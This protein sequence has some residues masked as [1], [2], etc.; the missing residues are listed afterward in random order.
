M[1]ACIT[2]HV[3]NSFSGADPAKKNTDG[4]VP[5]SLI[6]S[7]V[8][9][10][11]N[12]SWDTIAELYVYI[13]MY[14]YTQVLIEQNFVYVCASV[15]MC[16]NSLHILNCINTSISFLWPSFLAFRIQFV[17]LI[18]R[19][20]NII[21]KWFSNLLSFQEKYI[22]L[23]YNFF[24]LFSAAP[25]NEQKVIKTGNRQ[26]NIPVC[27]QRSV[28]EQMKTWWLFKSYNCLKIIHSLSFV[29]SPNIPCNIF[30]IYW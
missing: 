21:L 29:L 22:F 9:L 6:A 27:N 26:E 2:T 23:P 1:Y 18:V 25:E 4:K 8:S 13:Y 15:C 19:P 17:R 3:R 30:Q 7:N 16:D 11:S 5:K 14:V 10:E 24:K 20:E 28:G 12:K